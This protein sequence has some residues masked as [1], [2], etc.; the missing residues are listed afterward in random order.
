MSNIIPDGMIPSNIVVNF[1]AKRSLITANEDIDVVSTTEE[2]ATQ[3][4]E[5]PE[6]L[7]DIKVNNAKVNGVMELKRYSNLVKEFTQ[8]IDDMALFSGL[9]ESLKTPLTEILEFTES[10]FKGNQPAGMPDAIYKELRLKLFGSLIKKY[11]SNK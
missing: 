1:Q 7:R 6:A 11:D 2:Q 4:S 3:T 9:G 5:S 8:T 10:V